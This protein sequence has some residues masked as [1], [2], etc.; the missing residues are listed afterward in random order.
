[1]L[2]V[3]I[4]ESRTFNISLTGT[5]IDLALDFTGT[6]DNLRLSFRGTGIATTIDITADGDLRK[7]IEH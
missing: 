1:M 6:D 7:N 3:D 2:T 4:D 5:A